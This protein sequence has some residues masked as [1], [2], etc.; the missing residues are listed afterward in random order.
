[1]KEEPVN[2]TLKDVLEKKIKKKWI[3]DIYRD[4]RRIVT[5][6]GEDLRPFL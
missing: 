1:M 5:I 3:H 6:N 4:G 2:D